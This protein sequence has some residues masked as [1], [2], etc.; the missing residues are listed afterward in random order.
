MTS[1]SGGHKVSFF[2]N[3]GWFLKGCFCLMHNRSFCLGHHWTFHLSWC[4]CRFI[5]VFCL[6]SPTPVVMLM[7]FFCLNRNR[8]FLTNPWPSEVFSRYLLGPM[9]DF[10]SPLLHPLSIRNL[11]GLLGVRIRCWVE[12]SRLCTSVVFCCCWI[13]CSFASLT[14]GNNLLLNIGSVSPNLRLKRSCAG[15]TLISEIGIFLRLNR[16]RCCPC[17]F[18]LLQDIL[19]GL[20]VYFN[21]S[22]WLRIAWTGE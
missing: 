1:T 4:A 15:G 19:D 9:T 2:P 17:F 5:F 20:F 3:K 16:A 7:L 11:I 18:S 14:W 10:T 6:T 12:W 13:N 21:H 8:R 22:I